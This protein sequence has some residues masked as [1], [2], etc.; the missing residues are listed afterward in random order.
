MAG[1]PRIDAANPYLTARYDGGVVDSLPWGRGWAADRQ[2]G[3][4]A[5]SGLGKKI[6]L[7]NNPKL[8]GFDHPSNFQAAMCQERVWCRAGGGTGHA[9]VS[10]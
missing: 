10:A 5:T 4:F 7:K 6:T 3:K 8:K 2:V 9:R 1:Y